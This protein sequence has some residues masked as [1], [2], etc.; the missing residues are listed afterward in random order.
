M[1]L[2]EP[3]ADYFTAK[4]IRD[5][6]AM[7]APF[8]EQ[9]VVKDEG[10]ELRGR[11]AIR[12]WMEETTGKY[13]VTVEATGVEGKDGST[14]VTALVSGNFPGSPAELRYVF[15]LTEREI[16]RLEIG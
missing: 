14:V 15:E 12:A 16:A 1:N 11:A 3:I 4:N 10:Q 6:D 7:L 8:A 2:P 13:G 5:I 9:A